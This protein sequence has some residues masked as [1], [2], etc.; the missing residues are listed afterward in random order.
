VI[1]RKVEAIHVAIPSTFEKSPSGG[2]SATWP[3]VDTLLI[4]IETDD[5]IEGWGEAFGFMSCA[6]TRCAIDALIAPLCIGKDARDIPKL[7]GELFRKLHLYGRS[8]PVFYGLSGIDI[9][10][11]DIAGKVAQKPIYQLLSN[12]N[13]T[14]LP[15]YASLVRYGN[16]ATVSEVSARAVSQGCTAIKLHEIGVAEV[17]ASRKAIG[18][19]IPLMVDHNCPW[20]LEDALKFAKAFQPYNLDWM[21]EPIWPVDDFSAMAQFAAKS[22]I[23]LA[24]GENACS[25]FEFERLIEVGK[26]AVVQP[27]VTK[28][29]GISE[30]IKI[31]NF[32]KAR[33]V[34]IAPHSPYSGPGL[35]ATV[36]LC[37]ALLPDSL[38]EWYFFDLAARPFG[39]EV[40]GAKGR[41]I[42]PQGTG[43]GVGPDHD[44]IK[45]FRVA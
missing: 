31:V 20:S 24:A 4:R 27:S 15:S 13:V 2:P 36:H 10:L 40:D 19:D 25:F 26:V 42:V 16:A 11:W 45:R 1:I 44:V 9:A 41:V 21:E 23:R 18:D 29:G 33:G 30:M 38:I 7:M 3:T 37:A 32:A 35:A 22:P 43:L 34:Q 6:I 8:G 39:G 5:G 28:A 17:A 12:A 14:E